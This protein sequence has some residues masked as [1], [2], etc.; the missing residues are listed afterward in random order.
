MKN[1]YSI[2]IH[3]WMVSQLGL[4]GLELIVYA[5]LFDL[6]KYEPVD[7]A[8]LDEIRD[9]AT[10]VL[11]QFLTLKDMEE[12]VKKLERKDLVYVSN[13]KIGI[14]H[15][16]LRNFNMKENIEENIKVKK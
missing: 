8:Y 3:Y 2:T 15:S 16:E 14:S 12:A 1:Y 4:C 6:S 9:W 10:R 11:N 5:C 13:G 7:Y